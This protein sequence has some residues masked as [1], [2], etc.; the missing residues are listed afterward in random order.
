MPTNTHESGLESLIVNWL[1]EQNGYEQGECAEY[2]REYAVDEGR[3][4]RFLEDTQP[5]Q[6]AKLGVRGSGT[7]RIKFLDR[8]RGEITK[9]GVIDVLRNGI[10]VYPANIVMF[11]MTPSDKNQ[12]A[13]AMFGLNIFS[14]TRQLMYSMAVGYCVQCHL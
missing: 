3:L 8:L 5:E 6:A 12:K 1:V 9:R 4:F 7:G 14:V 13:K 11:Y 10:K 2:N